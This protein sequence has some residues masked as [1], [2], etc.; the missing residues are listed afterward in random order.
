MSRKIAIVG[1]S[2]EGFMQL[3]LLINNNR[4]DGMEEF[5]DDEYT[6]IH[7][8][9]KV[10]PYMMTGAGVAFQEVLER[11]ILFTKRWLEKYCDGDDS[12]GY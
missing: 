10:Y 9:D 6:L 3:A 7:D 11:E 8:P 1:A 12:C 4:Y 5:G 2:M